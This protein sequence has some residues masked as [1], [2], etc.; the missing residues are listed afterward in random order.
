MALKAKHKDTEF[1]VGDRVKV[2]QK[3]RE[4]E[5]ERLQVFDGIVLGIKG[6]GENKSFT[7]R[8]IGI[9]QIGIERI[10]PLGSPTIESIQVIRSGT[11]GI[12]RAKLY[13]IR[14]KSKREIEKIYSRGGKKG[15]APKASKAV[16]KK[17]MPK[18][19][20]SPKRKNASPKS[21]K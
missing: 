2:T 20:S 13:Y 1:G 17:V 3:V 19:K 4:G 21:K 18:K 5:K 6:E 16:A 9:Q 10:Y 11:V 15:V 8:R 14:G 12:K 7:V